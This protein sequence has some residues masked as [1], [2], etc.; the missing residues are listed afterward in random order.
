MKKMRIDIIIIINQKKIY[1][2]VDR[3]LQKC[4][5]GMKVGKNPSAYSDIVYF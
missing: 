4:S 5:R 3:G 1:Q 2:E